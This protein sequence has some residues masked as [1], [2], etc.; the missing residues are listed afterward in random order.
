MKRAKYLAALVGILVLLGGFWL[1]SPIESQFHQDP[2][3]GGP[4]GGGCGYCNQTACGCAAPPA[5][6]VLY[7]SCSCS[8]ISCT[9]SCDYQCG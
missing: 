4:G 9:R 8:S 1:A 6:C 7:Y 3:P 2:D 5:G